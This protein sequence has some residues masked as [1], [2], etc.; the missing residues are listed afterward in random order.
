MFAQSPKTRLLGGRT[1]DG[2]KSAKASVGEF[3]VLFAIKKYISTG[4][5]NDPKICVYRPVYIS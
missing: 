5:C 3:L 4:S 1:L 2:T